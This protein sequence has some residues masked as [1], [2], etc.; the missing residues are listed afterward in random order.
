MDAHLD[1]RPRIDEQVDALARR[2][3][4]ALMLLG[5]LLLAAA[6]LRLLAALVQIDDELSELGLG[7]LG[8]GSLGQ[9]R[10]LG[11][12]RDLVAFSHLPFHSGSRFSKNALTPSIASSVESSIVSCARR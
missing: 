2:Q 11:G 5:D 1:E 7:R 3:L 9:V 12:C 6:Q 10:L 8:R 4:A